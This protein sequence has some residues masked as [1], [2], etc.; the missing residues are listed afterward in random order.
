MSLLVSYLKQDIG[1][2]EKGFG[3][4][5]LLLAAVDCVWCAV[6]GSPMTED[7]F[8]ESGGA[9]V[10]LDLLKV[11][12]HIVN[13]YNQVASPWQPLHGSQLVES[14]KALSG[15]FSITTAGWS[16]GAT[17]FTVMYLLLCF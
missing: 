10:L 9:L 1:K 7:I 14:Q 3:P 2:F 13:L 6:V 5:R 16:Q 12:S 4:N 15:Q 8:L 11:F 17:D